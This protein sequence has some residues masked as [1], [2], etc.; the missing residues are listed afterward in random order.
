MLLSVC[1]SVCWTSVQVST[2]HD[3][4]RLEVL[5]DNIFGVEMKQPFT[6]ADDDSA[7]IS[8]SHLWRSNVAKLASNITRIIFKP[9]FSSW[10]ARLFTSGLIETACL[11]LTRCD[12][13]SL[14]QVHTCKPYHTS[15]D[16]LWQ[17]TVTENNT[18]SHRFVQISENLGTRC[19][20]IRLRFMS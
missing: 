13:K 3:V 12:M 7:F 16:W 10:V 18:L 19:V 15:Q 14:R 2:H 8:R 11:R 1:A 20:R 17:T 6:H 9:T 5:M 4:F